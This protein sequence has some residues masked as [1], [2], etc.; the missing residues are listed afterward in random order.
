MSSPIQLN[1]RRGNI[2]EKTVDMDVISNKEVNIGLD[3]LMNQDKKRPTESGNGS[4]S[5]YDHH[6]SDNTFDQ[7]RGERDR[8]DLSN[9]DDEDFKLESMV[10]NGSSSSSDDVRSQNMEKLMNRLD[11]PTTASPRVSPLADLDHA[12]HRS[13]ASE[14]YDDDDRRSRRYAD[15]DRDG[16]RE[17]NFGGSDDREDRDGDYDRYRGGNE[18]GNSSVY[19]RMSAAEE[20]QEKEKVI[21]ELE[22]MRRLGVQGI[23]RF[24]MSNDLEEMQFELNKIRKER[25]VESSIKFQRKVMMAF[26]TGVELLNN[27]FDYFNVHLDGWSETIHESQDEYNE[28]FEEL[29]EK[30]GTKTKMAPELRLLFML[31]GSAFMHHLSNSM[32]KTAM[33]GIGDILKQNPNLMND[34]VKA[35][36]SQMPYPEQR[37]AA[38]LFNQFAQMGS[39]QGGQAP[40]RTAPPAQQASSES[41]PDYEPRPEISRQSASSSSSSPSTAVPK[42]KSIPPPIGVEDVLQDLRSTSSSSDIS[43]IISQSERRPRKTL[44]QKPKQERSSVNS[45]LSL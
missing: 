17:R 20:R 33:P 29:H 40:R 43:E 4:S 16:D 31:A 22:K 37:Q 10:R 30:Y 36:S 15:E 2:T 13:S 27:K 5:S 1:I 45:T 9:Y 25:E 44:F 28:V 8:L 21:Y 11:L 35:A 12:G 3:L 7:P 6:D 32:F 23:K 41:M 42:K 38:G 34:F 24:N 39:N 14:Y 18:Y 19:P 26:V